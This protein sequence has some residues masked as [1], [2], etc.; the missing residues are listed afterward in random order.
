MSDTLKTILLWTCIPLVT[1]VAGGILAVVKKP[2]QAFRSIILHFAGG[3]IFS[4]VAVEILPDVIEMHQPLFVAI[5]FV[6][7]TLTMLLVKQFAEKDS[8]L[9]KTT[10][11]VPKV[12]LAFIVAIGVDVFIDG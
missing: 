12:P 9:E 2:N 1:F 4:V 11:I 5:G 6:V 7:G 3:V 10:K 8:N